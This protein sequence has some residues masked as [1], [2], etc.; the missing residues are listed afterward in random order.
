M[1]G[2]LIKNKSLYI[3]G[4]KQLTKIILKENL[5][6]ETLTE[7]IDHFKLDES[8]IKRIITYAY[9]MPNILI[10]I[11]KYMNFLYYPDYTLFDFI[12]A[13]RKILQANNR[14]NKKYIVYHSSNAN[15]IEL[16]D[17]LINLFNEYFQ[18]QYNENY[19][20]E[21]LKFYYQLYLVNK[22]TNADIIDIDLALHNNHQTLKINDDN[23][24]AREENINKINHELEYSMS[25]VI[26]NQ[27]KISIY[28]ESYTDQLKKIKQ[29]KCQKCPLFKNNFI[30]IEGNI[31]D[32]SNADVLIIN[33]SSTKSDL[34]LGQRFSETSQ[35]MQNLNSFPANCKWVMF[36]AINCELPKKTSLEKDEKAQEILENCKI[37]FREIKNKFKPKYFI[38]LGE[39]VFYVFF[40]KKNNFNDYVGTLFKNSVLILSNQMDESN[41]TVNVK[42]TE[43][44]KTFMELLNNGINS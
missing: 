11:N 19:N 10:Y 18:T 29:E 32:D 31:S 5:S 21:E 23:K 9:N 8:L 20:W 28:L 2:K 6:N 44:W 24:N 13:F 27:N 36:N 22:I 3:N 30:S 15:K 14:L 39:H 42:N 43:G 33:Y 16:Q 34:K 38:L 1:N 12:I 17:K 4:L 25:E 37:F 35:F 40:S 41:Y 26:D 7:F